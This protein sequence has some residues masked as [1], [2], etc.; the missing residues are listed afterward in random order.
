MS[1]LNLMYYYRQAL[2]YH[3]YCVLM[4]SDG[5]VSDISVV[6]VYN[7]CLFLLATQ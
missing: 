2:S 6:G 4:D 5:Q 1:S 7:Y 3:I